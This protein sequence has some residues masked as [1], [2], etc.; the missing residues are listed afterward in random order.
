M[1]L[2]RLCSIITAV[3]LAC[4]AG[5]HAAVLY[6]GSLGTVPAAQGWYYLSD[7]TSATQSVGGGATTLDTTL[8]PTESAG[9]FSDVPILPAHPGVGVLD[10]SV[11]FAVR[12]TAQV[13][14][15]NHSGTSG[16]TDRAGFSVIVINSAAKG[17]ELGFWADE[18][19]AQ[20]DVPLFTHSATE[21]F[22]FVTTAKTQYQLTFHQGST[23]SLSSLSPGGGVLFGGPLKDYSAFVPPVGLPMD[24]YETPNFIFF[25]DDTS[26]ASAEVSIYQI[27]LIPEPATAAVLL[28]GFAAALARRKRPA[29]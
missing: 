21:Q 23:Y 26:K 12:F 16:S 28:M 2:L 11:G 13:I 4:C 7:G 29:A 27:E 8:Q 25:G 20:T 14:S 22:A 6:D 15:E 18:I 17:V 3:A 9:Y 10:S 19:W 5:S 1:R 24:P